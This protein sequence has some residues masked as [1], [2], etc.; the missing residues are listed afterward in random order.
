MAG[1]MSCDADNL[2]NTVKFIAEA[3]AMGLVVERPDIN[4]SHLDFTVT[5]RPDG[6]IVRFGLGAVK[7]VGVSAVEAI[8]EARAAEGSFKSIF[9]IC[10]RVDTQK[11]NR[12][13]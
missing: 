5:P 8:L 13:V 7:G 6:K 2:D 4:E 1:L 10:T 11:C 3:R 9:E 12:R